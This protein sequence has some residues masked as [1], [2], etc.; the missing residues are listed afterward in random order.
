MGIK[1]R[2]IIIYAIIIIFGLILTQHLSVVISGSME[3]LMYRGD[4]VGLEKVNF[5]GFH[6]FDP[7]DVKIGDVVVYN[8]EWFPNLIIHRVINITEK[9]GTKLFTIKGDNNP[10]HDPLP[11]RPDQIVARVITIADHPFI[12][13]KIGYAAI[14]IQEFWHQL[15]DIH[16]EY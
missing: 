8:P 9:N 16:E 6:E 12:I 7:E 13:P 1:K 5:L 2:E 4:I 11:V 3:S 15:I 10:V 14:Y